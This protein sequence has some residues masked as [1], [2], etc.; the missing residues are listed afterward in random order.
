MP[1][2]TSEGS[3][4]NNCAS[5]S[6]KA[7]HGITA[8]T[9]T[10]THPPGHSQLLQKAKQKLKS[11]RLKWVF[12]ACRQ[13]AGC[14]TSLFWFLGYFSQSNQSF[15]TCQK[16]LS[17]VFHQLPTLLFLTLILGDIWS[18]NHKNL[19]TAESRPG[20][21]GLVRRSAITSQMGFWAFCVMD[22]WAGELLS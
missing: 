18:I 3:L 17:P 11:L 10:L 19:W 12:L 20:W 1:S 4:R 8:L 14:D 13:G 7:K 21:A 22:S 5:G 6:T 15:F 2:Y 16:L 9:V